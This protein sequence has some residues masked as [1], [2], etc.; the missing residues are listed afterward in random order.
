MIRAAFVAMSESHHHSEEQTTKAQSSLGHQFSALAREREEDH[1]IIT[2]LAQQLASTSEIHHHL[3]DQVST[4][5][6]Q[7][8]TTLETQLHHEKERISAQTALEHRIETLIKEKEADHKYLSHLTRQLAAIT[9][10]HH[11]LEEQLA[12]NTKSHSQLEEQVATAVHQTLTEI[13][14]I[15]LPTCPCTSQLVDLKS[16]HATKFTALQKTQAEVTLLR[17]DIQK[18]NSEAEHMR[19]TQQAE[20]QRLLQLQEAATQPSGQSHHSTQPTS[21]ATTPTL[22]TCDSLATPEDQLGLY[23]GGLRQLATFIAGGRLQTPPP[24]G[25]LVNHLIGQLGLSGHLTKVV[26]IKG[27]ALT[28][29]LSD[30]ALIFFRTAAL[31]DMAALAIKDFAKHNNIRGLFTKDV[32]PA[33]TLPDSF[34]LNSIG[35]ALRRSQRATSFRVLNR[36]SKLVLVLARPGM[37]CY[38]DAQTADLAVSDLPMTSRL[39]GSLSA[40]PTTSSRTT[41]TTKQ[42]EQAPQR[43]AAKTS[44]ARRGG[45]SK[46]TLT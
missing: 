25:W 24:A 38:E 21:A 22:N 17:K 18:L 26:L 36:Q 1:K 44:T 7:L 19:A 46:R 10:S 11:H 20:V 27:Q 14:Q 33:C 12:A 43:K 39:A 31:K 40:A 42:A 28:K 34:R 45:V 29:D 13:K 5:T 37:S 2:L 8:A 16:R 15:T 41:T 23:M 3:E 6:R 4:L 9:E 32:L 35:L 30:R